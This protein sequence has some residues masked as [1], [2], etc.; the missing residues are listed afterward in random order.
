MPDNTC[1]IAL[2]GTKFMG[3]AHSNA[4]LKVAKFFDLP[5]H[6]VMHTVVA[7]NEDEL[8]AFAARWGWQNSTTDTG[9]AIANPEIDLI[10]I[11]TPN[12]IHAEHAIAALVEDLKFCRGISFMGRPPINKTPAVGS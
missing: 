10:D 8:K 11:G 6:P 12:N 9:A 4:Y 2:I 7:R 1:N 5:L 3:R